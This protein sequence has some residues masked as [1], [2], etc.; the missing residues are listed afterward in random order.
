MKDFDPIGASDVDAE[1]QAH[2]D[3]MRRAAKNRKALGYPWQDGMD[4]FAAG[5]DFYAI[6]EAEHMARERAK[7]DAA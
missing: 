2:L 4:A 6:V 5:E 1:D 7:E 3:R